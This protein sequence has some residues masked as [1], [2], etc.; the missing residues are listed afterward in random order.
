MS[1]HFG[2]RFSAI[3]RSVS[4]LARPSRSI[5]ALRYRFATTHWGSGEYYVFGSDVRA[6]AASAAAVRAQ[7][8]SGHY[9]QN[10]N[11]V[12]IDLEDGDQWC[13]EGM[14]DL[15]PGLVVLVCPARDGRLESASGNV[16]EVE[17]CS[18]G[19]QAAC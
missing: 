14:V 6:R 7:L 10:Q 19:D 15:A 8:Q 16:V 1:P 11:S 4:R 12:E 13:R 5:R 9:L 3:R 2:Q 18:G 17:Q